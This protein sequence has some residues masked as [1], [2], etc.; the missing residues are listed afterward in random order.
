V[1]VDWEVVTGHA[2]FSYIGRIVLMLVVGVAYGWLTQCDLHATKRQVDK[3]KYGKS[4]I[5][6]LRAYSQNQHC[7]NSI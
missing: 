3:A 2:P 5:R 7:A 6:E 4:V 1:G